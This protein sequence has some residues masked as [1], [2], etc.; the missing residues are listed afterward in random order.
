MH[1]KAMPEKGFLILFF[2][3]L[4]SSGFVQGQ[5]QR[6]P[7]SIPRENGE[8]RPGERQGGSRK[9][10]DDSTKM[11]YSSR[12]TRF[13]LEQDVKNGIRRLYPIDTLIQRLNDFEINKKYDNKLQD[14]GNPGTAINPI[15]YTPPDIIGKQS[16]FNAFDYYFYGPEDILYYDTK[17]P[18]TDLNVVFGGRGRSRVDV[19]HSRNVNEN[20]NIGFDFHRLSALKQLS[21]RNQDDR[22]VVSTAYDLYTHYRSKDKSYELFGN[23]SRLGH[24]VQESGGISNT[25][26]SLFLFEDAQVFLNN[27]ESREVRLNLHYFHQYQWNDQ[28]KLYHQLDYLTQKNTFFDLL[29]A[30]GDNNSN[31]ARFY[32]QILINPDTTDERFLFRS[33]NNELGFKG[34][35]NNLFYSFYYQRRDLGFK[36]SRIDNNDVR[37]EN[38]GGFNLRWNYDSL[39]YLSVF[40]KYMLGEN[41]KLGAELRLPFFEATY[42]RYNYN[43]TFIQDMYLTNHFNWNNTFSSPESDNLY[44][45]I[46]LNFGPLFFSPK[47]NFH[48]V[49]DHIYY[50][51]NKEPVQADGYAQIFS[52]GLDLSINFFKNFVFQTEVNYTF[53]TGPARDIFFYP[54]WFVNGTLY[55]NN[56][57]FDKK[58]QVKI[59]VEANYKSPYLAL[60]YNPVNQQFFNQDPSSPFWVPAENGYLVTDFFVNFKIKTVR[61]FLQLVHFNQAEESGYF[62]APYYTGLP[63]TFDFG[64]NWMFFD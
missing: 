59:G 27:A 25:D 11:V 24:E 37:A 15:F 40:G 48:L 1:L 4:F 60:D 49:K 58:L 61:V 16:G 62:V 10:L 28:I 63:S 36:R 52:P 3:I 29:R 9:I 46:K 55:Y 53:E 23:F 42:S 39:Q 21:R 56:F 41:Y 51:A 54:D 57:L 32:D 2:L 6:Q 26:T 19:V 35:L 31:D 47:I 14:L 7:P 43:S 17:S 50:S 8:T 12:T 20:W 38:Y 44:A 33:L 30:A 34:D 45:A 18:Y 5:I 22:Q 64:V 13:L